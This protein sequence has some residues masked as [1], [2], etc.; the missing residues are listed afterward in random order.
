MIVVA[1]TVLAFGGGSVKGSSK[2]SESGIETD[3]QR[4]IINAEL[5]RHG[6]QI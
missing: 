2:L 1:V 6:I 5:P 3:T 4:T